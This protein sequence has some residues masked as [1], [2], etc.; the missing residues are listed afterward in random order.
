MKKTIVIILLGVMAM[1]SVS[2]QDTIHTRT[3]KS[4]YYCYNWIDTTLDS[5]SDNCFTGQQNGFL[6]GKNFLS[7]KDS[8][9]IIGIAFSP[10]VPPRFPEWDT[11]VWQTRW[12]YN[13]VL[14]TSLDNAYEYVSLYQF[15]STVNDY[16]RISDSL[17]V[18]IRDSVPAYYMDLEMHHHSYYDEMNPPI[19]IYEMY[20]DEPITVVDSFC[21]LMTQRSYRENVRDSSGT[22]WDYSSFPVDPRRIINGYGRCD[23][24][25]CYGYQNIWIHVHIGGTIFLFPILYTPE[26]NPPAPPDDTVSITTPQEMVLGIYVEP[27]PAKEEV[28]VSAG[29]GLR[30]IEAYNESGTCVYS[31][32]CSGMTA[33]LNVAAWPQGLYVLNIA[34]A[35]GTTVKKLVVTR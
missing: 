22:R 32:K 25:L 15:D 10:K 11:T 12:W 2:A 8:L 4:N 33:T 23:Y 14:D 28:T 19:A 16:V 5:Y 9:K 3:L 24:A 13:N 18:H 27:N 21:I 17:C 7:V 6:R 1:C 29:V 26:D 30:S 20:F 31:G 34:T 35:A